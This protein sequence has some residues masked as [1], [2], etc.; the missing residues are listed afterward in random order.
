[1]RAHLAPLAGGS[2]LGDLGSAVGGILG[3]VKQLLPLALLAGNIAGAAGAAGP[4]GIL[5][6]RGWAVAN[7]ASPL[8]SMI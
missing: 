4:G 8:L 7:A 3:P 2:L 5:Q 6:S 1:M